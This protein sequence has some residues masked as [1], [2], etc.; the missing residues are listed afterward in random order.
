MYGIGLGLLAHGPERHGEIIR[1]V[2]PLRG[3]EVLAEVR[4]THFIDPEGARLRV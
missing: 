4:P 3:E 2:D 1:A